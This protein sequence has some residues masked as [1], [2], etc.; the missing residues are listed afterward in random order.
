MDPSIAADQSARIHIR[1]PLFLLAEDAPNKDANSPAYVDAR[2]EP[3]DANG[4]KS[5][6]FCRLCAASKLNKLACRHADV[7]RLAG[8]NK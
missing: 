2:G 6:K 3:Q 4:K 7:W 8:T 1:G 5:D